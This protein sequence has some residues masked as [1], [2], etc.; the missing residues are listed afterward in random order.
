MA[1]TNLVTVDSCH[2]LWIFDTGEMQFRR[3]LKGLGHGQEV[4]R[5]EWRPYYELELDP[6]SDSFVVVLDQV[7]TRIL[8]SWRHTDVACPFCG[9][10]TQEFSL[11]DIAHIAS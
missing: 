6:N 9:G 3:I 10:D 5:T 7:G 1:K 11:D 2:S 4:A 8:R